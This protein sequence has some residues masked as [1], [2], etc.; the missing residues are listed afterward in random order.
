MVGCSAYKNTRLLFTVSE[1]NGKSEHLY[2]LN[3]IRFISMTW[4]LMGHV[5]GNVT[6]E[7]AYNLAPYGLKVKQG[8]QVKKILF[9]LH[10]RVSRWGTLGPN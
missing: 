2:C 9:G 10:V 4:V 1:K 5:C 8:I 3:G 7:P 6:L